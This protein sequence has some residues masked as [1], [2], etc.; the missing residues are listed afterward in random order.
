[1][2]LTEAPGRLGDEVGRFHGT[3]PSGLVA[4]SHTDRRGQVCFGEWLTPIGE[5]EQAETSARSLARRVETLD[6]PRIH[7][8]AGRAFFVGDS[9]EEGGPVGGALF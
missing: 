9:L 6:R 5:T 3:R 1:M 4:G 2:A 8:M 7:A